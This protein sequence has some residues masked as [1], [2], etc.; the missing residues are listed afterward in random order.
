MTSNY[1]DF[2]SRKKYVA[3]NR[4]T[5]EYLRYDGAGTTTDRNWAW[6]GQ[7]HQ[8]EWMRENHPAI[9]GDMV[10]YRDGQEKAH[11]HVSVGGHDEW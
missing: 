2:R 5:G 10:I 3:Y 11:A 6:V 1:T 9:T 7:P 4:R 8:A